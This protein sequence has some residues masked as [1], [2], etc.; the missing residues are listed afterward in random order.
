[1]FWKQIVN[2]FVWN[3]KLFSISRSS[4]IHYHYRS[5]S[6]LSV[7]FSE[8]DRYS[9]GYLYGSMGRNEC[10]LNNRRDIFYVRTLTA[11]RFILQ[12]SWR[13][14][15]T[16][17]RPS[18]NAGQWSSKHCP[19][20]LPLSC[21]WK[22]SNRICLPDPRTIMQLIMCGTCFPANHSIRTSCCL[23][24]ISEFQS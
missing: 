19:P 1:M 16:I 17:N 10:Q 14:W 18:V 5:F 20:H 22:L 7:V 3:L 4:T 13:T 12:N 6:Y 8:Q 11:E 15:A 9:W 21:T 24:R 23:I 2:G